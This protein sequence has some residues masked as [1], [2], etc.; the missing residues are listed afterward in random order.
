MARN[1]KI[2]KNQFD[3]ETP[4]VLAASVIKIA[5]AL[6]ILMG[7]KELTDKAIVVLIKGMPGMAE[8]ST[9]AIQ[10]VIENIK[11]LKSYYVRKSTK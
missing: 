11:K 8:V 2:V 3:P 10:L 5:S 4:E 6:E 7:T 9:G 1:V